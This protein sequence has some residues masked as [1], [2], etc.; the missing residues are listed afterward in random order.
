MTPAD[1]IQYELLRDL[2]QAQR[3]Y[4]RIVSEIKAAN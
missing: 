2:G 1:L 4:S 3:D